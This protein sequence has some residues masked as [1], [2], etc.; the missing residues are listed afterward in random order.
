MLGRDAVGSTYREAPL[1]LNLERDPHN[2]TWRLAST[3]CNLGLWPEPPR[4]QLAAVPPPAPFRHACEA[5]AL[6]VGER[7]GLKPGDAVLDCGVGYADQTALWATHFRVASVLAVERSAVHVAA[8]R[9]AQREGR[10]A[11]GDVVELCVGSATELPTAVAATERAPTL[12]DAVLCLDC[13]YH[14]DSRAKFLASAGALLRPGG[15][16][17]AADLI[18]ADGEVET[19][20]A[21]AGVVSALLGACR[22]WCRRWCRRGARRAVAALC[23]IPRANLHNAAQYAASLKEAELDDVLIEDISSRVFASFAAHADS[24]RVALRGRLR[25]GESAFLWMIGRLFTLV[26]RHRLF[27]AVLV[28]AR[29][30]GGK[31]PR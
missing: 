10:L 16:F 26:A 17:A 15:R 19:R 29:K 7:A 23:D 12:F 14:F 24:Q 3:W 20:G 2:D 25:Y 28:S 13:A 1:L 5:L 6:A 31:P 11:G 30:R 9:S 8:A 22:R 4:S 27:A 21:N 18:V